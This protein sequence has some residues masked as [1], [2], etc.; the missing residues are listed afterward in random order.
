MAQELNRL[1]QDAK[2]LVEI[3][4]EADAIAL[5]KKILQTNLNGRTT[6]NV[7]FCI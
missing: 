6:K 7:N 1:L 5:Y 2:E 3:N 4:K